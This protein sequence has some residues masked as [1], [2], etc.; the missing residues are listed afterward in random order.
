MRSRSQL[1]R[2]EIVSVTLEEVLRVVV[3]A[4]MFR[5]QIASVTIAGL[6]TLVIDGCDDPVTSVAPFI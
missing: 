4:P 2:Q 3:L 5:A 1:L 6:E